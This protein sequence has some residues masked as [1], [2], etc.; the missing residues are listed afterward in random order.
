MSVIFKTHLYDVF[1]AQASKSTTSVHE[2]KFNFAGFKKLVIKTP[3]KS[4]KSFFFDYST[5]YPHNLGSKHVTIKCYRKNAIG[6]RTLL[7]TGQVSLFML[8][9]GPS[10]YKLRLSLP[11]SVDKKISP[12]LYLSFTCEFVQF[13]PNCTI[14]IRD[15]VDD[16]ENTLA[17]LLPNRT[18]VPFVL[19][20]P[21]TKSILKTEHK[22]K[23]SLSTNDLEKCMVT[24][25][26]INILNNGLDNGL[27]I[28]TKPRPLPTI[29]S[30]LLENYDPKNLDVPVPQVARVGSQYSLIMTISEGPLYHQM[31]ETSLATE[32]GVVGG[33]V[34]SNY[35][36]PTE[37]VSTASAGFMTPIGYAMNL[38]HALVPWETMETLIHA[39]FHKLFVVTNTKGDNGEQRMLE[40]KKRLERALIRA[41]IRY[42]RDVLPGNDK[43]INM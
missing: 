13:C 23:L 36:L 40:L 39:H 17:I 6:Y 1:L 25:C 12:P 22:I 14:S 26:P 19:S 31:S 33:H 20:V 16:K 3:A 11:T 32:E 38:A 24:T 28:S 18:L 21:S 30:Y 8:A 43:F 4:K 35:P 37:W 2:I 9:T 34:M 27:D 29:A 5:I 10:K 41:R 7:A 42:R 15:Y